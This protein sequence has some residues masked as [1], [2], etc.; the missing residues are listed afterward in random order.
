MIMQTGKEWDICIP[1]VLTGY[2]RKPGFD[3]NSP[4]EILYGIKPRT[5]PVPPMIDTLPHDASIIREFEMAMTIALR[6][7][8]L[9]PM[10][11]T[12]GKPFETG[13]LVLLPL[14]KDK[15]GPK[16]SAK[17]WSGPYEILTAKHLAYVLRNFRGR[18]SRQPIYARRL[19]LYTQREVGLVME[20]G[21]DDEEFTN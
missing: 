19:R 13:D 17:L 9:V 7:N 18:R 21:Q 15:G 20:Y 3:G 6:A 16:I 4:F 14:G 11:S 2:R 5:Q 12:K 10:G 8:R 1:D